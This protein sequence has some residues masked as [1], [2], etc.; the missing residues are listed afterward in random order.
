MHLKKRHWE[1]AWVAESK[2][3]GTWA[4]ESGKNRPMAAVTGDPRTAVASEKTAAD[5]AV[6]A[7]PVAVERRVLPKPKQ[8]FTPYVDWG[9]CHPLYCSA[10]KGGMRG[11]LRLNIQRDNGSWGGCTAGYNVRSGGGSVN[12]WGWVLTA[13][14]CV[15]GK[16]NGTK[17]HHN[18]YNVLN[19]H[20]SA[21]GYAMEVNSYPYDFAL[22]NYISGNE[23]EPWLEDW[24]GSGYRNS[25]LKYCRNGGQDSNS[26]TPC[27][28]QAVERR[29]SINGYHSLSEIAA[30]W[31]VC[32][33]GS[34]THVSNYPE[35]HGT[36]SS[37]GYLVGTR[38]GRVLST[39]VGINTDVCAQAG[40]SGGPLFSQLDNRAYGILEGNQQN[41]TGACA[42]GEKNNYVAITKVYELWTAG[43]TAV[44]RAAQPSGSSRTPTVDDRCGPSLADGPHVYPLA[45]NRAR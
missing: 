40:D 9:I 20:G 22:L 31:I 29:V 2:K 25:V 44:S 23:S 24:G 4:E 33:S 34:G 30:G 15:V 41:Q 45:R 8:S 5:K 19:P 7:A 38:C 12:G 26:D 28:D 37:A 21:G 1:R 3:N 17:I 14:H 36:I 13:G 18:G 10:T 6:A 32:A 16:T 42:P 43:G 27:G 11:G 39:D 35:S